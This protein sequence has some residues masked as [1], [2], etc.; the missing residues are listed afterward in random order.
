L[1]DNKLEFKVYEV[2]L[3]CSG[4]TSDSFYTLSK[5]MRMENSTELIEGINAKRIS[6]FSFFLFQPAGRLN[7]YLSRFS[8]ITPQAQSLFLSLAHQ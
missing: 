4:F 3:E 6:M 1:S 2:D 7:Q 5:L 8:K